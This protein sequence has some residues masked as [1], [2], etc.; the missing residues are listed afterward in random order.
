MPLD[1]I[2]LLDGKDVLAG[3]ID[4]A[5]NTVE[6]PEE[7]AATIRAALAFVA[8][9]KLF[10][11]TNCGMAPDVGRG[12]LWQACGAVGGGG[13]GAQGTRRG[14]K[15]GAPST[16]RS[17]WRRRGGACTNDG[18]FDGGKRMTKEA[19]GCRTRRR[20]AT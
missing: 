14:L 9:E 2:K 8:P 19:G 10:P 11:C 17:I 20:A 1:L 12:R 15:S 3:A 18:G 6:T 7:V 16:L 5:S 4:V 13:A